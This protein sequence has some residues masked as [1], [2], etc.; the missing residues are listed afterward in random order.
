[1]GKHKGE[2]E[3][4]G[5]GVVLEG[6]IEAAE[7]AVDAVY[8]GGKDGIDTDKDGCKKGGELSEREEGILCQK[9]EG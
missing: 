9:G 5:D 3:L 8:A 1:M 2:G 4:A 6:F 7:E